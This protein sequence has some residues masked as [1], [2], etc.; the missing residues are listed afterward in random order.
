MSIR[1]ARSPLAATFEIQV[2]P[3]W[4]HFGRPMLSHRHPR[5]LNSPKLSVTSGC[6]FF[7]YATCSVAWF[8]S[9]I[10]M[11][12]ARSM[13]EIRGGTSSVIRTRLTDS[14]EEQR[15]VQ[16]CHLQRRPPWHQRQYAPPRWR[17]S[18]TRRPLS[19]ASRLVLG[20]RLEGVKKVYASKESA[21]KMLPLSQ[22]VDARVVRGVDGGQKCVP[23]V[24]KCVKNATT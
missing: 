19:S 23:F 2:G 7:T 11:A 5:N 20:W 14:R 24:R 13:T 1:I 9:F 17:G 6:R 3:I 4:S 16:V 8:A 15:A 21:S 12:D 22:K 18:A 10:V